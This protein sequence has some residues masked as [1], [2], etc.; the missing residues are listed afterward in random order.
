MNSL[1]RVV[2]SSEISKLATKLN[3]KQSFPPVIMKQG[4]VSSVGT[5]VVTIDF[6]PNDIETSYV[7]PNV[8]YLASYSPTLN[9]AVWCLSFGVDIICLGKLA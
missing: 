7:I 8:K 2:V 3:S 5:L 9:D 4:V 1:D 6:A